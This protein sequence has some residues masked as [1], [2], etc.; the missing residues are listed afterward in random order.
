MF[1]TCSGCTPSVLFKIRRSGMESTIHKCC[2]PRP[3]SKTI[4]V[5]S[6]KSPESGLR[7]EPWSH[8]WTNK[9]SI[10]YHLVDE[11]PMPLTIILRGSNRTGFTLRPSTGFLPITQQW[12]IHLQCLCCGLIIFLILGL[13]FFELVSILFAIVPDYGNDYINLT[14]ENDNLTNFKN[15]APKLNLNHN[16]YLNMLQRVDWPVHRLH[17]VLLRLLRPP[18]PEYKSTQRPI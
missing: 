15:F 16:I 13:M 1:T 9:H 14:K 12:W 7:M 8:K 11:G 2:Q 3:G 5:F 6:K 4:K 10:R 18:L 17:G